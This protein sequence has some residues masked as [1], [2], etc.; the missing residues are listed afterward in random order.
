SWYLEAIKPEYGKP[1]DEK[2]YLATVD[3]FDRQLKVLHPFMPFITEEIWQYLDERKMGE[4]IMVQRMPTVKD[5]DN[6]IFSGF[7]KAME[8]I[9]A[10]RSVRREKNIS[11]K[12]KIE[13]LYT[14]EIPDFLEKWSALIVKL[15]GLSNILKIESKPDVAVSVLVQ[16]N[17]LFIPITGM[18]DIEAE[19]EKVRSEIEYQEGFLRGVMKKLGNEKFVNNAPGKVVEME[20]KKKADAETKLKILRERLDSLQK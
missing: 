2:T 7:D 19:I 12:E 20:R 13:L 6:E 18:I 5:F 1:I 10:I 11:L 16:S 17:E 15:A 9:T 8:T 4:S 14:G 3:F